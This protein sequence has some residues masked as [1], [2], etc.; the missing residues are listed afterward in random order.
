MTNTQRATT[1]QS[2]SDDSFV[3]AGRSVT[4]I[5]GQ[6]SKPFLSSASA[7]SR[8]GTPHCSNG[9][10]RS[11]RFKVRNVPP[12]Q[13]FQE[14]IHSRPSVVLV[15]NDATHAATLTERLRTR[16]LTFATHRAPEDALRT[17]RREHPAWDI[18]VVNVSDASQPWLAILR[19]LMETCANHSS[20]Q[21]PLFL[22]TSR[23]KR[24]PQFQLA[25]ERLGVRFVYER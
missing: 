22:C 2:D 7:H 10:E 15:D 24:D 12:P 1:V 25:L 4:S 9:V 8:Q 18:V 14:I 5:S 19:R 23:I 16:Q 17:L 3:Y 20:P 21:M 13:T 6:G 11:I